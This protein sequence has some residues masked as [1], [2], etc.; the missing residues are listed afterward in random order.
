MKMTKEEFLSKLCTRREAENELGMTSAALQHHLRSGRI[1]PCK[2]YGVG[3]GK[4]Q[5]FWIDDINKLKQF[6]KQ[7]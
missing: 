5:L 6:L 1:K 3:K 7:C 2:E 4:V